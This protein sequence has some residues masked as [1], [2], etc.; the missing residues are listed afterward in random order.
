MILKSA[1]AALFAAS[2]LLLTDGATGARVL[3]LSEA[4]SLM[5]GAVSLRLSMPDEGSGNDVV[6]ESDWWAKCVAD[7]GCRAAVE[8]RGYTCPSTYYIYPSTAATQCQPKTCLIGCAK[9]IAAEICRD[10][11][12]WDCYY[13]TSVN[14][15]GH[16]GQG[17][18]GK[19]AYIRTDNMQTAIT[20]CSVVGGCTPDGGT[21]DCGQ[22][23]SCYDI[24]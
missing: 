5:G 23:Q 7:V 20:M 18:T 22:A 2:A 11:W 9:Q 12:F 10:D 16:C 19:C 4:E 1:L 8:A 14:S 3:E 21:V 17:T 13:D 15:A 24:D 6:D